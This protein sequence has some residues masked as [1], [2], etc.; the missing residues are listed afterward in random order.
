MRRMLIAVAA[1]CLATP[2]LAQAS[3]PNEYAEAWGEASYTVG[4]CYSHLSSQNKAD[5]WAMLKTLNASHDAKVVSFREALAVL[6]SNGVEDSIGEPLDAS[7]CERT[8]KAA[9]RRISRLEKR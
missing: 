4:R 2:A 6:Y 3:Q 5:Y 7:Q 9:F 8:L 1:M